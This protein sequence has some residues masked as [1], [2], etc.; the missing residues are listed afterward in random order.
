MRMAFTLIKTD[1]KLYIGII[2]Q[3]NKEMRKLSII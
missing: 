1:L 3:Q 2:K